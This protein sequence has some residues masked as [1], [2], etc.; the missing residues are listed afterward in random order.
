MQPRN[1]KPLRNWNTTP[2]RLPSFHTKTLPCRL[3]FQYE[4]M[5]S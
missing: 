1:E 5:A 4:G 2:G 3:S